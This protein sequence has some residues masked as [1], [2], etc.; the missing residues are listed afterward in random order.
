MRRELVAQPIPPAPVVVAVVVVV[1]V[2]VRH[3][4]IICAH[5]RTRQRCSGQ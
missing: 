2:V 5:V 3:V 1:V 4:A